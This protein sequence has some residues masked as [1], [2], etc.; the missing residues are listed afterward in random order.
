MIRA[1]GWRALGR[2]AAFATGL[3]DKLT[4]Q[5]LHADH[6]GDQ[7]QIDDRADEEQPAG[8]EPEE[9]AGPAPEVEAVESENAESSQKPQKITNGT[10]FHTFLFVKGPTGF[11]E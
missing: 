9:P 7:K 4:S 6:L 1:T 2:A 8:E 3:N 10:A 5:I 11:L